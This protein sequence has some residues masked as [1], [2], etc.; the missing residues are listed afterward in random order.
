MGTDNK[1][2]KAGPAHRV[3]TFLALSFWIFGLLFSEIGGGTVPNG[4]E[5][6]GGSEQRAVTASAAWGGALARCM[7]SQFYRAVSLWWIVDLFL[8]PKWPL[9]AVL[10]LTFKVG[11]PVPR[12]RQRE[13][14]SCSR[15]LTLQ[16]LYRSSQGCAASQQASASLCSNWVDN[17]GQPP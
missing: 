5:A 6:G 4:H 7:P 16:R 11:R 2:A 9:L 12:P 3:A 10:M 15:M 8:L 14:R 17:L 13:L 1:P